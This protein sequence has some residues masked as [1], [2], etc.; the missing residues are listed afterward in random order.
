MGAMALVWM[1]ANLAQAEQIIFVKE[2]AAIMSRG[3]QN[4][5]SVVIPK[6]DAKTVGKEWKS[7]LKDWNAKV[8][9]KKGE[10]FADNA[11]IKELS[12]NNTIDIYS[13]ATDTKE[14]ALL[15][16]FFDLGGAF[17]SSAQHAD[18]FR[19]AENLVYQFAV[20]QE[21]QVVGV[22]IV[23]GEKLLKKLQDEQ[24]DLQAK[25]STLLKEIAR[26]KEIIVQKQLE[27]T[28][29]EGMAQTNLQAQEAKKVEVEN[30]KKVVDAIRERQ[31]AVQ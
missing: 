11:R 16:V 15:T 24:I 6:A 19:T 25:H 3:S 4:A 8:K 10:I 28:E 14:G 31:I 21:K 1:S 5:L 2:G 13:L 26:N 7:T 12:D 23:V 29:A 17:L 18:K 22:E 27:I 9:E 20:T 30:Q